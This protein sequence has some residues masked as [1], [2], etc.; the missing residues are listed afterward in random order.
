MCP[1]DSVIMRLTCLYECITN[2]FFLANNRTYL[3]NCMIKCDTFSDYIHQKKKL[4]SYQVYLINPYHYDA[5]QVVGLHT[6]KYLQKL[7]VMVS[8]KSLLQSLA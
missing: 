5:T 6:L 1:K 7:H 4:T 8:L 3:Y 2:N